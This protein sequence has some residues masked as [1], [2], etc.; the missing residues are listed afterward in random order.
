[1]HGVSGTRAEELLEC[2]P[3]QLKRLA[4]DASAGFYECRG[5]QGSK[6]PRREAYSWGGLTSGP[7]TR[8][9]WLLF[10]P[11]LLINL[12]HWMLPPSEA[13]SETGRRAADRAG[14]LL[15]LLAL[16]LTLTLMLASAQ[17][18]VDIV[19]WQCAAIDRCGQQL[20]PLSGL[21]R[22]PEG[23]RIALTAVPVAAL[24]ALLLL[25][26][27]ANP[28]IARR[29]A[30]PRAEGPPENSS[31]VKGEI[32][33]R[34]PR[35][36]N[37]DQ[38]VRR[39]R[40]CHIIAWLAG[41]SALTAAVPVR[42]LGDWPALRVACAVLVGVNLLLVAFAV[43]C[44][45]LTKLTG[46]GGAGSTL[47]PRFFTRMAILSG[48]LC[49]GTL[50][51]V[52]FTDSDAH[53]SGIATHLPVL[54]NTIY[55]LLGIQSV[56]IALVFLVTKRCRRG[57]HGAIRTALSGLVYPL[58]QI[59]R[60]FRG[61]VVVA[62]PAD[63]GWAPSLRGFAAPVV[64]T[65]ALLAA[66]G[67]SA[68]VGLWIAQFLGMAVPTT[69]AAQCLEGFRSTTLG[70]SV[71]NAGYQFSQCAPVKRDQ[72]RENP[73]FEDRTAAFTTDTPLILPPGYF[74]AA[75]VFL[76]LALVLVLVAGG[77][78]WRVLPRWRAAANP[79][80]ADYQA[81]TDGDHA[82]AIARLRAL[83]LLADEVP[84]ILAKL[85]A[86]AVLALSTLTALYFSVARMH[87]FDRV[88]ITVPV[89]S[90][91][92]VA[93]I[94]ATAAAM[95]ALAVGALRNRQQRR[96][97]GIL[98][99]VITFWPR[100]NHPLTPPCYTERV[101]PDLTH[102]MNFLRN[103]EHRDVVLSAHSQGTIIAAA[104]LLH[105]G[106]EA[107]DVALLTFGCPLRRLYGRNFP[108]Y[109]NREAMDAIAAQ[110]PGRWLNL[111]VHTD[112]IGGWV[113]SEGEVMWP[114]IDAVDLATVDHRLLDAATVDIRDRGGHD[115]ICGHSGFWNRREYDRAIAALAGGSTLPDD[116]RVGDELD[117]R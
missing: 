93:A 56:L 92:S 105:M 112:P 44:T 29:P 14:S 78:W 95:V 72:L 85:T 24:L 84:V 116:V 70:S 5:A 102:E 63:D 47:S 75:L 89:L 107:G 57:W 38:S 12:A 35:F 104:T 88:P 18:L 20:G 94:T 74:V 79:V 98:W 22:A 32:P 8:G 65:I 71:A 67:F 77:V 90:T 101:V 114:G 61:R 103:E 49:V 6:Q 83:A 51:V 58:P 99:D 68:G 34:D 9:L 43:G 87:G 23:R 96:V 7:A 111:W 28:A 31:N 59:W 13:A 117:R 64:A 11:F 76:G 30:P 39:M 113:C 16:T 2:P 115:P 15:R 62:P 52:G 55:V 33:L 66:G 69:A 48:V 50:V 41:L 109:F 3:Q 46:R 108:A 80:P 26:G 54:R 91:L 42:Y 17:I 73:T 86:G 27:R 82:D 1:M 10:L 60:R 97:I 110:R 37:V 40:A 106:D 21:T 25:L 53:L 4:G 19:G 100:A 81:P 45:G 36:W